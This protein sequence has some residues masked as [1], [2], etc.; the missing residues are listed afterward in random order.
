VTVPTDWQKRIGY[1]RDWVWRG[2]QIR[3]TFMPSS[4]ELEQVNPPVILLHGFGAAIEH[5]RYNIPVLS[6]QHRV[7][8]LD[9]LGFGASRKVYTTYKIDL[10][11]EQVYD[12]W[13]TF[14]QKPV[15]L[16]GNSIGSLVCLSAATRYPE[17]VKGIAMLSL[18][19]VSLRQEALPGW[20]MP[21]VTSLENLFASPV[22]LK[23]LFR[24][25]RSPNMLRKWAKFAY[26]D[27]N[28]VTD[29]LLHI[30][31]A[32]AH[33]EGAERAFCALCQTTRHPQFSPLV[34]QI[35]PNLSIPMLLCWGRQD[36]MV[37]F[38]LAAIFCELNSKIELVD[39]DRIGHCPH[40]ECPDRFNTILLAWLQKS[41]HPV[42]KDLDGYGCV[43]EYET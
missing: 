7:Y 38:A 29:E 28:A 37:P 24:W 13:R 39:L 10:W 23:P 42:K 22:L 8:A 15:I 26:E 43:I 34:R 21:L 41:F 4:P 40:D 20:L 17:M 16:V 30:L 9:L 35:L 3:Y 31:A 19:D 25:L 2:W 14:I 32:P 18:P 5:W 33:D 1:Q 36:R 12:F 11:V 27:G 6:Q